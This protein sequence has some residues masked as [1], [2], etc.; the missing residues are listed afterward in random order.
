MKLIK[1]IKIRIRQKK[2]F[3]ALSRAVEPRDV[4]E[5][6]KLAELMI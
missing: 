5:L 4:R 1:K 6:S 3:K 2:L